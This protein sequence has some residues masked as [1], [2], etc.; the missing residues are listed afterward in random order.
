MFAYWRPPSPSLN[1]SMAEN[2]P[3][4]QGINFLAELL[5][6]TGGGRGGGSVH[7]LFPCSQ[8]SPWKPRLSAQLPP[9]LTRLTRVFRADGV[10]PFSLSLQISNFSFSAEGE[11]KSRKKFP[12]RRHRTDVLLLSEGLFIHL[13]A[14][15]MY[16][17]I[18]LI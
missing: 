2:Q 15:L 13:T 1:T 11:N 5:F 8:P 16:I 4:L 17:H 14:I 3:L 9:E 12:I 6:L 10:A 18:Q 7:P